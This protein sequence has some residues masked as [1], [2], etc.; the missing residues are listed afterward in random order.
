MSYLQDKVLKSVPT[1]KKI[2]LKDNG[3]TKS[4]LVFFIIALN[5]QTRNQRNLSS[6]EAT[7]LKHTI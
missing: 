5:N 3:R 7:L 2:I 6:K 1:Q 4:H